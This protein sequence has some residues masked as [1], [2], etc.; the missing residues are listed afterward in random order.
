MAEPISP[1]TVTEEA[2][3]ALAPVAAEVDAAERRVTRRVGVALAVGTVSVAAVMLS[4]V[5]T[6]RLAWS[7]A[8]GGAA[9]PATRTGYVELD[10][11]NWGVVP[12]SVDGPATVSIAGVTA[13]ATTSGSVPAFATGV[14]RVDVSVEDCARVPPSDPDAG[15]TVTVGART[16]H[17][18]EALA[19][20]GPSTSSLVA[21][22]VDAICERT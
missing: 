12:V 22:V 16:W 10:V 3:G 19:F 9:D 13:S 6:P 14:L 20:G 15:A 21:D 11:R 17:G 18:V 4:G 8:G 7:G 2:W 1:Y 5:W